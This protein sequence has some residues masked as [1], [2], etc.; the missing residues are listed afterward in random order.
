VQVSSSEEHVAR[1]LRS[2]AAVA[3]A[4]GCEVSHD[5]LALTTFHTAVADPADTATKVQAWWAGMT[6]G[7]CPDEGR[8]EGN[9]PSSADVGCEGVPLHVLLLVPALPK[10]CSVEIQPLFARGRRRPAPAR[11]DSSDGVQCFLATKR[12]FA[13]LSTECQPRCLKVGRLTRTEV[14]TCR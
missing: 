5:C 13:P 4:V 7:S 14:G 9:G 12:G 3:T 1:C 10:G 6:A 2:C 8:N 11:A